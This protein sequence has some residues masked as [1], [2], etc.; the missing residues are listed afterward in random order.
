MS[1]N[2]QI[3]GKVLGSFM[4]DEREALDAFKKLNAS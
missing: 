3:K 4:H 2:K 1:D